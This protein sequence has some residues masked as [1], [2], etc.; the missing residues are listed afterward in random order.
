MSS[1]VA[2]GAR[3]VNLSLQMVETNCDPKCTIDPI[4]IVEENNAVFER[5]IKDAPN[6]LW[7]IGAGNEQRPARFASPASLV[8]KYPDRI[9]VVAAVTLPP[10]GVI[11]GSNVTLADYSNFGPLVEVAAPGTVTSTMPR[12][13]DPVCD[14][15]GQTSTP[16]YSSYKTE[17]SGTSF[18]TPQV[19]GLAALVMSK[20]PGKSVLEVK[21]CIVEGTRAPVTGN[22]FSGGTPDFKV[23]DAAKA[24]ECAPPSGYMVTTLAGSGTAGFADGTGANASFSLPS[25]VAVDPAGNVYVADSRNERIRKITPAGMV[26]TFANNLPP[27]TFGVAVDSAGNVYFS[28]IL[29]VSKITPAGVRTIVG[30]GG[31]PDSRGPGLLRGLVV[32]S[33]GNGYVADAIYHWIIKWN[34][35]GERTVVGSGSAGFAD[36]TGASASFHSPIGVALDSARNVYVADTQNHRIR[37]ITPAGVVSTLAGSGTA[38]FADGTGTAA[39]FN[40]PTGVTVAVGGDVYVADNLNHRI[41]KITPAGVVTTIA[42]SGLSRFADGNGTAAAFANP[43]SVAVDLLGNI[44]VADSN[45]Q[46]IRKIT[47]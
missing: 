11:V 25:G 40:F 13:C 31:T 21:R 32:D 5:A 42:G 24:V 26:S 28:D 33:V 47:P 44:Y 9:L 2:N 27:F 43:A 23:I 20:F 15:G 14:D 7:V 46:R 3:I 36:G 1:A 8:E 34:E 22:Q 29:L 37:K 10:T 39:S 35:A 41:R 17:A 12:V 38:G 16:L 6:V 45:N 30:G 19:A 4:A 18:A